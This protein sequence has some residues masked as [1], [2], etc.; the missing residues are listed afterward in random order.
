[1]YDLEVVYRKS[2]GSSTKAIELFYDNQTIFKMQGKREV[3]MN[4]L[5]C[6]FRKLC[7]DLSNDKK[8]CSGTEYNR[9][10]RDN[11]WTWGGVREWFTGL[12]LWRPWMAVC[13]GIIL[14]LL[15]LFSFSS[16][17]PVNYNLQRILYTLTW[18]LDGCSFLQTTNMKGFFFFTY[19]IINYYCKNSSHNPFTVRWDAFLLCPV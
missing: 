10:V 13:T 4:R 5:H 9:D 11:W 8:F 12:S 6:F 17:L 3:D 1:M 14:F 16:G 2:P 18:V 19:N 7:F 15:L